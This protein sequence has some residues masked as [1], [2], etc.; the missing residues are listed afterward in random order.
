[1]FSRESGSTLPN[2]YILLNDVRAEGL[3]FICA[4]RSGTVSLLSE[5]E[6]VRIFTR[7]D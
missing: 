1:M 5:N 7:V 6:T 2:G 4:T 3:I